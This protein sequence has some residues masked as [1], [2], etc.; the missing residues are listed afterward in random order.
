MCEALFNTGLAGAPTEYFDQDTRDR[1]GQIW[2]VKTLNKSQDESLDDYLQE[3]LKRKSSPNGVFGSKA[4]FHQYELTFGVDKLPT[5]FTNL[6][7]HL[8]FSPRRCSPSGFILSC[9]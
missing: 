9:H 5:V 7:I 3:L 8:G 6:E 2:H 1:F 4:H